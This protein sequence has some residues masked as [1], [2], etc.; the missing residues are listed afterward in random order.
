MGNNRG[1]AG[2][3]LIQGAFILNKT[4]AYYNENADKFILG[5]L[6][7]DMMTI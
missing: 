1:T 4:L 3:L 7:V 5:T 2:Y 6:N